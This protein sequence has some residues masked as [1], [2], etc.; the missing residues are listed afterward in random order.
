M[1]LGRAPSVKHLVETWEVM[2]F[3]ASDAA[4]RFAPHRP[5]RPDLEYL[6]EKTF[7]R[8]PEH[9]GG[10]G[11]DVS[12]VA[13]MAAFVEEGWRLHVGR[14]ALMLACMLETG[15][16]S[17]RP[18]KIAV[19]WTYCL[20]ASYDVKNVVNDVLLIC[21]VFEGVGEFVSSVEAQLGFSNGHRDKSSRA[22]DSCPKRW[23]L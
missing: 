9:P 6:A 4:A 19:N 8:Q 3:R 14:E 16:A 17:F 11:R 18:G 5:L 22:Q 10:V 23:C 13:L 2:Q 21:K 1:G 7:S 12:V 20:F 15:A